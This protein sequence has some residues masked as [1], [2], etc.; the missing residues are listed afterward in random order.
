M[1]IFRHIIFSIGALLMTSGSLVSQVVLP[2]SAL[3]PVGLAVSETAQVN[4]ANVAVGSTGDPAPSCQGSVTF[5]N[6]SGTAIGTPT[7]FSLGARQIA[8]VA[9]P[10]ASTGA[11]GD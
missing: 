1:K 7:P 6:A 2:S 8:S 5:Y 9:V 10:Y 3:P 11:L 4:V